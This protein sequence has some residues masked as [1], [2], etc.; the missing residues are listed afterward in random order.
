M[1][2]VYIGDVK[3]EKTAVLAPMAGVCDHAQRVLSREFGAALVYG[4]MASSAGLV[5]GGRGSAPNSKTAELLVSTD[6][7]K[8][9]AAQ[10]FGNNPEFMARAA[11][12]V[13][14]FK[15]C[16]IDINSGCPMPKITGGGAGA[17]LLKTPKLLGEIV[18]SV[19][20]AVEKTAV[21]S[22]VPV[23]VKIRSGW[24]ESSKNAVEVAKICE[25]GGAS[26][27]TVHARTREQMYSG[28]ADWSIIADVKKAVKIPVIGNGDVTSAEKCRLMYGQTGC[29]LVMIGRAAWG[30]PWIFSLRDEEITL[31]K[32]LAVMTRHVELLIGDKGEA[33]AMK[34]ARAHIAKYLRGVRGA[35]VYRNMCA[36]LTSKED[37]LQ[38]IEKISLEY[39]L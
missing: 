26:A 16:I 36:N 28:S 13:Q 23:T 35:A 33:V 38:L 17:A 3:I 34:Q 19:V 27:V 10:I 8:P 29:D 21:G 24:D 22:P 32:R 37:F 14:E 9:F 25:A 6:I 5:Y 18:N 1:D 39:K 4:E 11:E 20:K 2:Y 30:A 12:I 31:Q 15:P 7:E